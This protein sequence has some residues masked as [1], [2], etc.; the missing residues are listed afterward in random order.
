MQRIDMRM[1]YSDKH[2]RIISTV[3]PPFCNVCMAQ[4]A[5]L[6]FFALLGSLYTGTYG[7]YP[8]PGCHDKSASFKRNWPI[9]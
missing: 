8:F 6:N 7:Q 3:Q 9:V 4:T 2:Y 1:Q 5:E